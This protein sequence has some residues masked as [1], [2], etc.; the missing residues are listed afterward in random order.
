MQLIIQPDGA[1]KCVYGEAID[2]HALGRVSISRG[3][4]VEA[5]SNGW[6][7]ADLSP[8]AGPRLGPFP[9]RSQALEAEREWL[10]AHWLTPVSK[11]SPSLGM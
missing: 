11:S 8:V 7:L 4:H 5:D 1:L 9:A 10:E 2:L 3:S 6:W